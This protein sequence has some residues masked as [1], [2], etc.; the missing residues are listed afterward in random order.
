MDR[1]E[2]VKTMLPE[3]ARGKM[4]EGL[5]ARFFFFGS[6]FRGDFLER[7]GFDLAVD[8]AATSSLFRA[9]AFAVIE[10]IT[11]IPPLRSKSTGKRSVSSKMRSGARPPRVSN[12]RVG[13]GTSS[14]VSS[15]RG[16]PSKRSR[17]DRA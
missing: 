11:Q 17:N 2:K 9:E 5:R 8:A 4:R 14:S 1:S 16:R 7:S 13:S 3:S 12:R 15:R 10:E 6:P